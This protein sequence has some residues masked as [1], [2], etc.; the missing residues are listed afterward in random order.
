MT[1]HVLTRWIKEAIVGYA[2]SLMVSD[3]E[4]ET[5]EPYLLLSLS[6]LGQSMNSSLLP[7]SMGYIAGL[8]KF[9]WLEV[10]KNLGEK[11]SEFKTSLK[12]DQLCQVILN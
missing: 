1:V 4:R 10:I 11:N 7:P 3:S 2:D 6:H 8:T 5:D 12:R 9:S